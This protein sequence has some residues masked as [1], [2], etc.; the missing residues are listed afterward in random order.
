MASPAVA[1][2]MDLTKTEECTF[3]TTH[4]HMGIGRMRQ[5]NNLAVETNADKTQLRHQKK[6]I[7]SPELDE[8]RSQDGY[9]QRHLNSISCHY[10]KSTRF[11]PNTELDA[12]YRAMEAYRT[13]R[14]PKLVAAFM[15]KY[16]ELE[17]VDFAPLALPAPD[18]LGDLFDRG[19]YPRSEDVN[20]G[21][22]FTFELRPVGKINLAGL[23][24]FIVAMELEKEQTKR[25]AAVEQWT[26]TMRVA[27]AGVVDG[28]FE[29]L[30]P[31]TGK[32]KKLYDT[33]VS[34]LVDFCRT[35]PTRNLGNDAECAK[36]VETIQQLM[37]GVS[38]EHL[39]NSDNLKA[40][41]AKQL[42][43]VRSGLKTMVIS[44][45]RKFR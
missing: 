19:D 18:G 38:V 39:R 41:V 12:L 20:A 4:F 27:L 40:H 37:S 43:S 36:Q 31:E 30:T 14:R 33:H 23:P 6:M 3:V 22:D 29:A 8:I 28:L 44:T 35:F 9:L 24:D 32:R 42:E 17:L 26:S 2:K 10:D 5:V 25:A 15:A 13:I 45:G 21:F 11:V 34:N 7:D 1:P 16:R